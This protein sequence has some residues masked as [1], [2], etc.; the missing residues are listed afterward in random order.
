[1]VT[2]FV[3]RLAEA[4]RV[5]DALSAWRWGQDVHYKPLR[6]RQNAVAQLRWM[7]TPEHISETEENNYMYIL[8]GEGWYP[9]PALD[10]Y[11]AWLRAFQVLDGKLSEQDDARIGRAITILQELRN[12]YEEFQAPY[13]EKTI[14]DYQ[15]HLKTQMNMTKEA[16]MFGGQPGHILIIRIRAE[17]DGS[18][19]H[20]TYNAG[21][22][23]TI[24]QQHF[25]ANGRSYLI[26]NEMET[27]R[28]KGTDIG[29]L[30]A[31]E[32][33]KLSSPNAQYTQTL[34]QKLTQTLVPEIIDAQHSILQGKSNC[35][36]RSQRILINSLLPPSVGNRLYDFVTNP[37]RSIAD[38]EAA[39]VAR[40]Q[41]LRRPSYVERTQ[42]NPKAGWS[43]YL[44]P[45]AGPTLRY[46]VPFPCRVHEVTEDMTVFAE[47]F[48]AYTDKSGTPKPIRIT[49]AYKEKAGIAYAY[50]PAND[51]SDPNN[52]KK[53]YDNLIAYHEEGPHGSSHRR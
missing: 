11:I 35:T 16:Y 51:P 36:T 10:G 13:A 17:N 7:E 15:S 42:A 3:D 49:W 30:I 50:V 43:F 53:S 27:R 37:E 31:I 28:V 14:W 5:D 2:S 47:E 8:H 32:N 19:T 22:G 48:A 20:T 12:N 34:T 38:I 26:G 9:L 41:Q 4:T 52:P 40:E 39:L 46:T 6:L 25:D 18:Y 21:A 44:S 45:A 23:S 1:M 24:S 29:M 33:E